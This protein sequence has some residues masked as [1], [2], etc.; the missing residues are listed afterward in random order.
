MIGTEV[1]KSGFLLKGS[2]VAKNRRKERFTG[3]DCRGTY[4]ADFKQKLLS[5]NP[6]TTLSF[7]KEKKTNKT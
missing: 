4:L 5:E 2:K 3:T 1:L 7:G 6:S